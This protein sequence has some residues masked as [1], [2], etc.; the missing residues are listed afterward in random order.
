MGGNMQQ[1]WERFFQINLDKPRSKPFDAGLT[2]ISPRHLE[3]WP[4]SQKVEIKDL[5]E[6]Q[7]NQTKKHSNWKIKKQSKNNQKNIKK[8]SEPDPETDPA[9]HPGREPAQNQWFDYF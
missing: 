1:L 6:N 9:D 8:Q 2:V 3:K 7:K 5:I 4:V